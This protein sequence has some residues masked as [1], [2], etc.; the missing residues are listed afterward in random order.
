[1]QL[2]ELV[3]FYLLYIDPSF[4]ISKG[5]L[6]FSLIKSFIALNILL[7]SSLDFPIFSIFFSILFAS[8]LLTRL[9]LFVINLFLFKQRLGLSF[10]FFDKSY[11]NLAFFG[12]HINHCPSHWRV[13]TLILVQVYFCCHCCCCNPC[14]LDTFWGNCCFCSCFSFS[15]LYWLFIFVVQKLIV[16]ARSM[17]MHVTIFPF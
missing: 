5:V 10:S 7:E 13:F 15:A 11:C 6:S 8:S 4:F 2:D 12:A 17:L 1:M 16:Y 9:C 14:L 3:V